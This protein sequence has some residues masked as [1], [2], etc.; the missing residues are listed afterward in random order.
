M[1]DTSS[2]FDI[3]LI[4]S[5]LIFYVGALTQTCVAFSLNHISAQC[6]KLLAD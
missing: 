5:Y 4:P 3:F 1:T 2:L 6:L